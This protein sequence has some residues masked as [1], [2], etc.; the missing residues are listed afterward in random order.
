MCKDTTFQANR[1]VT[2]ISVCLPVGKT[3]VESE[4]S[5]RERDSWKEAH[6]SVPG[7]LHTLLCVI[8]CPCAFYCP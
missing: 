2:I 5:T 7:P 1:R 4:I 8:D 6:L 3:P